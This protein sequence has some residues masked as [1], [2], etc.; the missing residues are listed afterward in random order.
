[1]C[2]ILSELNGWSQTWYEEGVRASMQRWDV[3]AEDIDAYMTTLPAA[4]EE[5]VMMQK[6]I[7]LYMQPMEAWSEYRRTGYPNTLVRPNETYDYTYP[8]TEG[9]V[10]ETYT[11]TPIGGMTDVPERNR[12]PLNE[13][14]INDANLAQAI[15]RMGGDT[16]ETP[17]WWAE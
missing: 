14:S 12:Y 11:F 10:T 16:Q 3:P 2:F 1:V 5:T 7:A 8:T 9:M 17:L 13:A 4:T 6:Y 15:S